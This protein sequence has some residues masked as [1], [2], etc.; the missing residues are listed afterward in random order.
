MVGKVF[1]SHCLFLPASLPS[2]YIAS[3]RFPMEE[4]GILVHSRVSLYATGLEADNQVYSVLYFVDVIV[5]LNL[6]CE[7]SCRLGRVTR[8]E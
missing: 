4:I 5:A 7:A 8:L 3:S 1:S 6:L 2:S